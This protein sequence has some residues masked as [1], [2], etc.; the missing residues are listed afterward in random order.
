MFKNEFYVLTSNDGS[1]WNHLIDN[2]ET[3]QIFSYE[4]DVKTLNV[5]NVLTCNDNLI[6]N[7]TL[8]EINR[9]YHCLQILN[10][11]GKLLGFIKLN[12]Q[13]KISCIG[14]NEVFSLTNSGKE[15]IYAFDLS[16]LAY[17]RKFGQAK[18]VESP[19]YFSKSIKSLQYSNQ[20]FYCLYNDHLNLMNSQDGHEIKSIDLY[21]DK[22]IIDSMQNLICISYQRKLVKFRDSNGQIISDIELVN[23]PRKYS[24]VDEQNGFLKF[25]N[26]ESFEIFEKKI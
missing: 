18:N 1:N 5:L 2:F 4:E 8:K 7:Y 20:I 24:L 23:F 6:I 21:A 9:I 19:F 3:S 12:K 15:R 25:L 17:F 26:L 16:N 13:F 11:H 22:L 14:D 10:Q